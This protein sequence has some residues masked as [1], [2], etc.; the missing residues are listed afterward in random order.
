M[1]MKIEAKI[2][3]IFF[4]S[5]VVFLV[6]M[7]V[8]LN[9][10]NQQSHYLQQ[11]NQETSRLEV[12][13]Q[14][15]LK[16]VAVLMPVN[17]FLIAGSD[18]HEAENFMA[19]SAALEQLFKTVAPW[20]GH[21]PA[22]KALVDHIQIEYLEIKETALKIFSIT[23]AVGD[24][25]AGRLMEIMDEA[26]DHVIR[27]SEAL[28]ARSYEDLLKTQADWERAER[29]LKRVIAGGILCYVLLILLAWIFF[30]RTI[31]SPIVSLRNAVKEMAAG[32]IRQRVEVQNDDEIG[33]LEHSFNKMSANL[34]YAVEKLKERELELK[35]AFAIKS[36][37]ASVVSDKLRR[38]LTDLNERIGWIMERGKGSMSP[39]LIEDLSAAKK[40]LDRLLRFVDSPLDDHREYD[41]HKGSP[42]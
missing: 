21:D 33:E 26:G 39:E 16:L 17:D 18:P 14:L 30:K 2:S 10:F 13:R 40:D 20:S 27:D 3:G 31:S 22:G 24:P 12:I 25:E 37:Y 23:N 15:Q 28:F 34:K 9:F 29:V 5:F 36:S 19:Q 38:P 41:Q 35:K 32:D 4:S 7:V 8:F 1:R 6:F 42:A 11:F